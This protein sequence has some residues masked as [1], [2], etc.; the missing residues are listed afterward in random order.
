[1]MQVNLR[2][3]SAHTWLPKT[4]IAP[5]RKHPSVRLIVERLDDRDVAA[6]SFMLTVQLSLL[7]TLSTH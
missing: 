6:I 3:V 4:L 5:L 1:M 7:P 2:R